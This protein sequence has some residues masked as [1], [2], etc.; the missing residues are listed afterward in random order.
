MDIGVEQFEHV[1]F[2]VAPYTECIYKMVLSNE[3]HVLRRIGML[4]V[5]G[6]LAP[7]LKIGS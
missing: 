4:R 5:G 2:C 3:A 7:I 6:V 1:I